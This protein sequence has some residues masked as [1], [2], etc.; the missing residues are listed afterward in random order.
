MIV[1]NEEKFLEGC[2]QSVQGVADEI[3][4]VDTGSSD[5]TIE[6]AKKY[7][8]KIYDINWSDD[9][10]L[11]R[12][13]ALRHSTGEWILYL[14]AD[15]RLDISNK[16]ALINFLKNM[17]SEIGGI[18]CLIESN[19]LKF[20]GETE[21]H[22]GGYPRLFRNL[23]Y[24][25]IY[26]RG[27]VHE[28]ISPSILDQGYSFINSDI[29]IE[30]LGYNQSREVMESK[31]RRNYKLLLQHV[32]EEPTNGYAWYQLGQTLAQM[33]LVKEAEDAVRMAIQCG[34]LSKSVLASAT[35]TLAQIVGNKKN[36]E[37]ALYWSEESLK[38]AP[39]QVFALHL[40]AFALLYLK[41]FDESLDTFQETL[42][43]MKEKK[44][45]PQSGFDIDI[46]EE[47]ILKGI[48]KAQLRDASLN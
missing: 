44:G 2:L 19:H 13:E 34:N 18:N 24:P 17:P 9:F 46:P 5:R 38:N 28:Q 11:A 3:V 4:I 36:F 8:D 45:I 30:H 25:N 14:D 41:R 39:E 35:S 16:T 42:L 26:F 32:K 43:R 12:N 31:I 22:R 47:I 7:T 37:E 6:I 15:E 48:E 1:K 10:A 27:R 20:D 21:I 29:K 40:K 23:G 33:K